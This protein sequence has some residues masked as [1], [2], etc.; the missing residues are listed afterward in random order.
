VVEPETGEMGAGECR[1]ERMAAV[2][3]RTDTLAAFV[4]AA[5]LPPETE[6]LGPVPLPAPPPGRPRR[7]GDPPPGEMWSRALLRV[8]PGRGAALARALK[9]ARAARTARG[10]T[11]QIRIRIDPLDIG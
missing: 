5:G 9:E 11:D 10:G 7:P 2:S 4:A 1:V 6:V 8:P 3:G